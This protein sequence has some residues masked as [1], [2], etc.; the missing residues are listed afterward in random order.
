M[1]KIIASFFCLLLW[2]SNTDAQVVVIAHRSVPSDTITKLQLL[3][4]YTGDIR[5][6]ADDQAVV[7]LDLKP[8]CEVKN[9][10]YS[11]LGKK[12]SKMKSIWLRKMLS[13]EG[14]PPESLKS[15]EELLD[16]VAQT[17]GAIGFVSKSKAT[18]EVKILLEIKE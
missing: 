14:Q 10:F 1:N 6:W 12:P 15:E 4:F 7:V 8:K 2:A 17:T 5:R 13:G 9:T 16:K 3:D 18:Q 11:Y